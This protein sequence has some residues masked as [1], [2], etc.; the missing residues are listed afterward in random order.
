MLI[1]AIECRS[2]K[3]DTFT[4]NTYSACGRKEVSH[5][6]CEFHVSQYAVNAIL[7][8]LLWPG[9]GF[10]AACRSHAQNSFLD[11]ICDSGVPLLDLTL[12]DINIEDIVDLRMCH[13][14]GPTCSKPALVEA[15]CFEQGREPLVPSV[16]AING[17]GFIAAVF[18]CA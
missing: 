11:P 13:E 12:E 14:V 9:F 16:A 4:G 6:P 10:S 2:P 17:Q 8:Q 7:A 15:R 1:T 18:F 5:H 3:E